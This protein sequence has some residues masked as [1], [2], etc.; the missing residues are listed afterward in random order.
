MAAALG[1]LFAVAAPA[2]GD[3][4]PRPEPVPGPAPCAKSSDYRVGTGIY[5]I[6]GPAA[7]LGMMGYAQVFQKTEGIH[8]RLFARAFVVE[9]PCNGRRVAVVSAD[10]GQVFQSVHQGVV[11]K[12]R[13]AGLP[14]DEG[15]VLISATHTH[16]GPGG[17]SHYA[18]Y[19]LTVLGFDGQ[20]FEA[21]TDGIFQAVRRAHGNLREGRI[22]L[23]R[24]ELAGAS[25]NRS[26]EAYARN[27]A[28]ERESFAH[29]VDREMTL[30]RFD[31]AD[32]AALGVLNWFAVHGTSMSN[33]NKLITGDNKG[34]AS[35]LFEKAKGADHR[36]ARTFVAAFAQSNEGDVSPNVFEGTEGRGRDDFDAT[37]RSGRLQYEKA[38]QLFDG[39]QRPV[40]GPVDVRFAHVRMSDLAVASPFADGQARRTCPGALGAASFAGAEDGPGFGKEGLNREEALDFVVKGLGLLLCPVRRDPCQGEKP[41]ALDMCH[42]VPGWIPLTPEVLPL[43]IV[44]LGNVALVAAPFEL[45]TMAGRRL[46]RTVLEALAPAGVDTAVIAG[47]ANAYAHYATT[48]EEYAAQHYEGASTHFGPWTLDALRQEFARLARA[49]AAGEPVPAGPAPRDLSRGQTTLQTGVVL[50]AP[51][52]LGA[53]GAVAEDASPRYRPGETVHVAF[54][55]AHPKN[56][57]R[58]QGT[59]LEVQRRTASGWQT[60]ARDGDWETRF[61]WERV[62]PAASKAI[63]EWSIPASAP[64]GTYRIVHAGVAKGLNRQLS[65][66][67][68]TSGRF[69]VRRGA[70]A[71]CRRHEDCAGFAGLGR[72]GVACCAGRCTGMKRDYVG[73]WWCPAEC[74]AS[75]FAAPGTCR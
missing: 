30:L 21:I 47:L 33:R 43:Q 19:N 46:R 16:G 48:R 60:V 51:P 64:L 44:R 62:L 3:G 9:S 38:R 36:R 40:T 67:S 27:P 75:L 32:G 15:N 35:Y 18:L 52:L 41:V 13:A 22:G 1:L 4:G 31:G 59:F 29:D 68:G 42:E 26:P 70:G 34:Y 8:L 11:R 57:L 74:R 6:T 72:R 50:D 69:E 37:A 7:E 23:S 45:T 54:W 65:P 49:M 71:S 2:P 5:D 39:A 25:K 61:R 20:N 17:Y 63:V 56:D 28:A 10:L 73:I 12:L 58:T 24:G 66:Y 14:Y 53:F 55:A